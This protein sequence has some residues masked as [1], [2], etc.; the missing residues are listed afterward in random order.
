MT[1]E[2]FIIEIE[3]QKERGKKL[4]NQVLQMNVVKCNY[5]DCMAVFGTPRQYYTPKEELAPVK[6]EYTSWKSYV[7]DYLLSVLDANDDFISEWSLCLQEP[8]RHDVSDKEWYTKEIKEALGKLDS[9]AQRI[10]FRFKEK[11]LREETANQVNGEGKK[12]PKIFI[13]HSSKDSTIIK[14]FVENVLIVGLGLIDKDVAFTSEEAFGVEP[15]ENIATY[16][17]ENITGACIVLIMLSDNYKDSEVCLNEMGATWALQKKCVSVLLPGAG[18]DKLGWLTSLEKAVKINNKM[19]LSKLCQT[20]SIHCN[21]NINERFTIATRKIDEFIT[22]IGTKK[23]PIPVRFK[24][25]TAPALTPVS[26]KRTLKLFDARFT[27]IC[28]E[29]GDYIIQLNVR[30]RA[31]GDN[32]SLRQIFLCNKREFHGTTF[33]PLKQM[34]FKSFIKQSLFELSSDETV[35]QKYLKEDYNKYSLS[36]MDTTIE[37]GYNLSVSFVQFFHTIRQ[38]DGYDELPLKG[39]ALLVKYNVDSEVT[40]PFELHPLDKD[41]RGKYLQD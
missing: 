39:W 7:H 18:F 30:L 35:A 14:N 2:G 19:Q 32:V 34:E 8:Y 29:E 13:S 9:F 26:V 21:V 41:T 22:S 12:C 23:Q 38:M 20:I 25:V 17:K 4:L 3:S 5:G 27:G 36:I 1:K 37:N 28:L 24:S 10:E 11:A 6:K 40:I 33:Q 16:I 31:E 15:G